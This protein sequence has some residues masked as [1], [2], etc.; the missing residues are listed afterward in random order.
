MIILIIVI[1]VGIALMLLPKLLKERKI[2]E[3]IITGSLLLAGFVLTI[4]YSQN[5]AIPSPINAIKALLDMADLH[6]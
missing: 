2:K 5:A 3:L 4:L 6:Y 1:F